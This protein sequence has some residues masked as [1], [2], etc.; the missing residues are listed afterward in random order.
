MSSEIELST[1]PSPFKISAYL[2]AIDDILNLFD[3][4]IIFGIQI[5]FGV[6]STIS[7]LVC[8]Q[9]FGNSILLEKLFLSDGGSVG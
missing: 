4:L 7:V 9:D 5:L 6:I 2:E 3:G 1:I 8:K